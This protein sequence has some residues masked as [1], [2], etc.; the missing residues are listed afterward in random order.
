MLEKKV[1][2][3]GGSVSGL[4]LGIQLKRQGFDPIVVE[5]NRGNKPQIKGEFFQPYGVSLLENLGILEQIED[6]SSKIRKV[7]HVYRD[8]IWRQNHNF[9]I[10]YNNFGKINYGLALP[11]DD[12]LSVLKSEYLKLGGRFSEGLQVVGLNSHTKGYDVTFSSN[13]TEFFDIFVGAD[14]RFSQTRKLAGLEYREQPFDRVMMAATIKKTKIPRGVFYTEEVSRGVLY[15]FQFHDETTRIYLCFGKDELARANESREKFLID[16]LSQS[17][18]F[19]NKEIVGPVMLMPTTDGM[20]MERSK[21][22]GIW[23]G[24]AAGTVDPLGGQGMTL[25]LHDSKCLALCISN[26]NSSS[27]IVAVFRSLSENLRESYLHGR[28]IGQW[29]GHLF[30]NC[31]RLNRFAKWN[32]IKQCETDPE[33][34]TQIIDLFG[35]TKR[36]PFTI[37][38]VPYLLGILPTSIRQKL[39]NFTWSRSLLNQQNSILTKPLSLKKFMAQRKSLEILKHIFSH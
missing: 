3:C 9:V 36:D 13:K 35:G 7:I 34:R 14:G 1:L 4:S 29:I 10:R 22:T 21:G 11:H 24:D 30:M 15:A 18:H 31:D 20:L 12:I 8:P 27:D 17:P 28:F 38:D 26:L 19:K 2:I 33:R 16:K 23:I 6:R 5:K 37:Y 39:E 32:A 25:A